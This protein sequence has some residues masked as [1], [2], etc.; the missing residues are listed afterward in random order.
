MSAQWFDS[1]LV[2]EDFTPIRKGWSLR[3]TYS[4]PPELPGPISSRPP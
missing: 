1:P 3:K 4:G 2:P